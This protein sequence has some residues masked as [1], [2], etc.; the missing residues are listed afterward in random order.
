MLI[1]NGDNG[2]WLC[3]NH[4]GLFDRNYFCFD[5]GNGKVLIRTSLD[6]G[7]KEF[8]NSTLISDNLLGDTLNNA[9]KCF[10]EKRN[11]MLMDN[12]GSLPYSECAQSDI[13]KEKY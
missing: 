12:T 7:S 9:T 3:K 5:S 2:I 8:F 13:N 1:N 4:H 11:Q 10:L 6:D